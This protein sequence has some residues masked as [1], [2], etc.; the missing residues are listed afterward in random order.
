[1]IDKRRTD[2]IKRYG[3]VVIARCSAVLRASFKPVMGS[4]MKNAMI[5]AKVI[6]LF[7]KLLQKWHDFE[8]GGP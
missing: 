2:S 8:N 6:G 3:A 4:P 7:V 1:M 5:I